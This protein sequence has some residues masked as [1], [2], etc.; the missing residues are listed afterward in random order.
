MATRSMPNAC[1]PES[2]KQRKH[3]EEFVS[4]DLLVGGYGAELAT[5]APQ[6]LEPVFEHYAT[7][8]RVR[9]GIRLLAGLRNH[10]ANEPP[11]LQLIELTQ[12]A[13]AGVGNSATA[14]LKSLGLPLELQDTS[15]KDKW[16]M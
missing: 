5:I 1:D 10:K 16:S 7:V 8:A 9:E 12:E 14:A 6:S 4:K 3:G 2:I 11:P 13:G 15:D